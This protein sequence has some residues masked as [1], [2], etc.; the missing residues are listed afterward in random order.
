MNLASFKYLHDILYDETIYDA[1]TTR[2]HNHRNDDENQGK[3]TEVLFKFDSQDTSVSLQ[4]KYISLYANLRNVHCLA[5]YLMSL[6]V[7]L[8][9]LFWPY[10]KTLNIQYSKHVHYVIVGQVWCETPQR[11]LS[12]ILS[13]MFFFFFLNCIALGCLCMRVSNRT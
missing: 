10:A 4:G 9:Q 8:W 11:T 5:V 6:C 13:L 2:A 12:Y 1:F 3:F 7:Y